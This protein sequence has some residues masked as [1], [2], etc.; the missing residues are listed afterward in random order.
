RMSKP[1]KDEEA[2]VE[3]TRNA[4]A[5]VLGREPSRQEVWKVHA[6]FK[7][8]AFM[9]LDHMDHIKKHEN[10]TPDQET[11]PEDVDTDDLETANEEGTSL[12]TGEPTP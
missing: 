10:E 4:L 12:E 9:L 1:N 8:M 2:L 6:G 11:Y 7:R 5:D 3:L